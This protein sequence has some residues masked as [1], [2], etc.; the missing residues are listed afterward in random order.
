MG[1]IDSIIAKVESE[2]TT[3]CQDTHTHFTARPTESITLTNENPHK[4][5]HTREWPTAWIGIDGDDKQ[6]VKSAYYRPLIRV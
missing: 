4:M 2:V 3:V 1:M 5:M 6:P